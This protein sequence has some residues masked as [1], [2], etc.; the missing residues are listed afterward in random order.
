MSEFLRPD[1]ILNNIYDSYTIETFQRIDEILNVV[2]STDV[3]ALA[4]KIIDGI[5][6]SNIIDDANINNVGKFRYYDDDTNSYL[7]MC[8]KTGLDTYEWINIKTN[9]W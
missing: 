4:I 3:K 6:I 7:D 1:E 5:T 9:T 2:Y 8:M